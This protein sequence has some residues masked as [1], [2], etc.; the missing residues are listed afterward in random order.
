VRDL[1]KLSRNGRS[2]RETIDD[3]VRTIRNN[4]YY[5]TKKPLAARAAQVGGSMA[6]SSGARAKAL[7]EFIGQL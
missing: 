3:Q 4:D 6:E 5:R 2:L 7:R 1:G